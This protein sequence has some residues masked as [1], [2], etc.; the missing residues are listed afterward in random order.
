M[1]TSGCDLHP[2]IAYE[3]KLILKECDG[4]PLTIASIGELLSSKPMTVLNGRS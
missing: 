4:H 2:D 1:E 3:G